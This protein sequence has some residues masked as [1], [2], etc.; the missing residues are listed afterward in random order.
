MLVI[1]RGFVG[2]RGFDRLPRDPG[3]IHLRT[4]NIA[5]LQLATRSGSST[6]WWV[7]PT[8]LKNMSL[9]VN[10]NDEV[11]NIYVYVYTIYIYIY[12]IQYLYIYIY[13][14]LFIYTWKTKSHLLVTTNQIQPDPDPVTTSPH[15]STL[16]R[17]LHQVTVRF[18]KGFGFAI[19]GPDL[20]AVRARS[21]QVTPQ[22]DCNPNMIRKWCV[23][24]IMESHKS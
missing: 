4:A 5:W 15:F 18:Q 24:I 13:I 3:N 1:T 21:N 7:Q 12:I 22:Q 20:T 9:S 2:Y 17:H 11:P 10:W 23:W 8:H 19:Q 16:L 14:Y 6:R